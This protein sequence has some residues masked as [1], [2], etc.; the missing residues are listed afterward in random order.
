[1]PQVPSSNAS[2]RVLVVG[3]SGG[4]GRAISLALAANG[5]RVALAARRIDR[6]EEAARSAGPDCVALQCDVTDESSCRTVV[7]NAVDHLGGLDGLVYAA[8]IG[9]LIALEDVNAATWRQVFDTNV[10]GAALVTAASLPHLGASG[11]V[12]AYLSSVSASL[13]PPWPGLGAYIVSKAALDKLVDAWRSEHPHIGFTGVKVGETAGTDGYWSE[14]GSG[15][16]P[17]LSAQA[18]ALW[19]SRGYVSGALVDTEELTGAVEVVLRTRASVPS[20]TLTPRPV[21]QA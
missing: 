17:E 8:G 7:A 12:A 14:L 4:L 15:W 10:I 5:A 6:I 18:H 2:L 21:P 19:T 3:A 1:M 20:I 13:T 11:G 9:P 16:D